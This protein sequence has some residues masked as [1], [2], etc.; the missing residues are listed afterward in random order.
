MLSLAV[1]PVGQLCEEF[2]LTCVAVPGCS[3]GLKSQQKKF[4]GMPIRKGWKVAT[5][6]VSLRSKLE[7]RTCNC[8]CKHAPCAG[9]DTKLTEKYTDEFVSLVLEGIADDT[10]LPAQSSDDG[11]CLLEQ[12]EPDAVF[13]CPSLPV[14]PIQKGTKEE[15]H[16]QKLV[17][18]LPLINA[19]VARLLTN[20]E[21]KA[22]SKAKQAILEEADKLRARMV[23]DE[24]TVAEY[25][26]VVARS[27]TDGKTRHFGRIH[28][29]C[30]EKGSELPDGHP[31]KKY[32]GRVVFQ[33]NNV[34][35]QSGEFAVFA[36]LSSCPVTIE[37]S[38]FCDMYGLLEGHDIQQADARQAYVQ[39][40]LGGA[41]T[42]IEMPPLLRPQGWGAFRRPVCR[43]VLALYG[44]PDSGGYWQQHSFA[45]IER[46]GFQS[47]EGWPSVF[48]HPTKRVLLIVYVDDIKIAGPTAELAGV[49]ESLKEIDL[50][51]PTSCARY[52]GCNQSIQ[53]LETC[54]KM[55]YDMS[56]FMLACCDRYEELVKVPVKYSDAP[57]PFLNED[58]LNELDY[59]VEGVLTGD[60]SRSS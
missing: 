23:W 19:A 33:G 13:A 25:D 39:S 22:D 36:E 46:A 54:R 57:T 15:Q 52:I 43:L 27:Q 16:R 53:E 29:I 10:A 42:W 1:R 48:I 60:A 2:G 8:R 14:Q 37:A 32:K 56:D 40:K 59:E 26:E 30:S 50:D 28:S 18:S 6:C 34:K 41:E 49:W 44:H 55:V 31:D 38:K 21:V 24:T 11:H 58:A 3:V 20:S 9:A 35:D 7:G 51:P 17:D 5:D 45:I 12:F 47:I 4:F